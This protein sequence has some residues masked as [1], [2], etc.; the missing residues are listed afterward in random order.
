MLPFIRSPVMSCINLP[1]LLAI[2]SSSSLIFKLLPGLSTGPE[3]VFS[4]TWLPREPGMLINAGEWC[5]FVD[6]RIND[7]MENQDVFYS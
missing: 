5:K 6:Q 7:Y 2:T 1:A 3:N 4:K